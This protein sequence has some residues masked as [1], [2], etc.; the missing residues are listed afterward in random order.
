M[1]TLIL[2]DF[3]C[4]AD[5]NEV[6]IRPLT[7][8]VG[9]NSTGKTSF[10]AAVRAAH[11]LRSGYGLDFNEEPFRLGSY[12]QIANYRG[13][14]AG[15]A[16]SF[17]VGQKFTARR[18]RLTSSQTR[19]SVEVQIEA[20]LTSANAQ[21]VISELEI[22]SGRHRLAVRLPENDQPF[23]SFSVDGEVVYE[24][25]RADGLWPRWA[26]A[27]EDIGFILRR[28]RSEAR[29]DDDNRMTDDDHE[30]LNMLADSM[31]FRREPRPH[32]FAPIRTSPQRT[33]E[34][35]K[36]I[37][38]PG[39]GHIPMM[40]ARL[41]GDDDASD[42]TEGIE[43]F[44]E[45]SGLYTSLGVH[46]L[47]RKG[48]DPFQI[49]VKH[50]RGPRRNLIDVGYGVSQAMPIIADC[51]SAQRDSTLLIQQPEVHLHPRAQAAM[52]SFFGRLAGSRR[53]R[54]VIETHSD[55][56]VDR[57]RMDVRDEKIRATDVVILYFEQAT[58][59]VG[60]HPIRIDAQGRV[61]GVPEGYRSFFLQ[62]DRR[63]FGVG[64]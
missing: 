18:P 27:S 21:P 24:Q 13:G 47:G 6:S 14:R 64:Q 12:D 10:L 52:G 57:V 9:E 35:I 16:K 45:A 59:G 11:D 54:L 32:A 56:L 34:P 22:S 42:F 37:R 41:L 44:G 26:R 2:E 46:K 4:F 20:R 31:M 61:S 39:G 3:R 19:R 48:S 8:L 36:E 23:V 17:V 15:R 38:D 28:I 58:G 49:Q 50:P 7:F 62:E 30:H 29:A 40:L 60:I 51:L 5:R 63:F 33:Y 53:N 1:D 25:R 55:Y 43:Q